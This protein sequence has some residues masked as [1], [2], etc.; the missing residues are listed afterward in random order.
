MPSL[1][2]AKGSERELIV[3]WCV[4]KVAE[5]SS[6]IE[7]RINRSNGPIEVGER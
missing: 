6:T 5:R 7:R 3:L 4:R 1:Y 2:L